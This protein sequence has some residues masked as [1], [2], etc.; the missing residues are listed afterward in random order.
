MF[1]QVVFF[2]AKS[3]TE[4]TSDITSAQLCLQ[5]DRNLEKWKRSLSY[6]ILA[7]IVNLFYCKHV[8]GS[9]SHFVCDKH[10]FLQSLF[11]SHLPFLQLFPTVFICADAVEFEKYRSCSAIVFI[12]KSA[13]SDDQSALKA[14]AF[15]DIQNSSVTSTA[16]SF[17]ITP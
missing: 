1:S 13:V 4:I 3:T 14:K 6:A 9:S 11:R 7:T 5:S 15:G 2:F 10:A 12:Q 17:Q 8:C 16:L